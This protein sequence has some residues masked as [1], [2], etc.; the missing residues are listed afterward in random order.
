MASRSSSTSEG[1]VVDIHHKANTFSQRGETAINGS[2]RVSGLDG[3]SDRNGT[4]Q[5]RQPVPLRHGLMNSGYNYRA[6]SRSPS[7]YRRK[8]TR[9]PSPYRNKRALDRSPS[10]FRHGRND[11]GHDGNDSRSQHKRK[12][13]PPRGSRP[14]KRHNTDRS[15][16]GDRL[17]RSYADDLRNGQSQPGFVKASQETAERPHV[18]PISYAE[19]DNQTPAVPGFSDSIVA[20]DRHPKQS[21]SVERLE[22]SS[23]Q[24]TRDTQKLSIEPNAGEQTKVEVEEKKN[25]VEMYVKVRSNTSY[26]ANETQELY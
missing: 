17:R 19:I 8:R 22:R 21:D 13:S 11:R 12:A 25:D 3:A 10:P 24:V 15:R 26:T 4:T 9:S 1:E 18:K 6:L 16:H 2:S 14:E 20:G 7:P 23:Q 5:N